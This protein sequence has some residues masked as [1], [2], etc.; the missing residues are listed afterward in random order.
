VGRRVELAQ[1]DE[2]LAGALAGQGGVVAVEG[3]AGVGKTRL[4]EHFLSRAPAGV[5]RFAA[6]CYE[7]DLSAPLEPIRTALDAWDE[8]APARRR[9]DLRFGRR[10]RAT[11]AT[12]C[13]A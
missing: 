13:A 1:L 4:I 7:R 8:A 6:R 2:C 3:E 10:S 11:A 9:D 12:S 5:A